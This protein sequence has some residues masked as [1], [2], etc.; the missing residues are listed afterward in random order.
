LANI[1]IITA[2]F[3]PEPVVS[4]GISYDIAAYLTKRNSVTVISPK[5][6][7]PY[8][9]LFPQQQVAFNFTHIISNSY[10]HAQSGF[11]GRFRESYSFGKYGYNY[12]VKNRKKIDLIYANTWPLMGQYFVV[13]A[14]KKCNIP[15][16]LHVQD[17]YPESLSK[18]LPYISGIVNRILLPLDRYVLKNSSAIAV[19]SKKMKNYL[20]K[21][22]KINIDKFHV[23]PNWQD[24]TLFIT[25]HV[26]ATKNEDGSFIFMYL[27]NVGPV[28]G[29]ELLI[30]AFAKANIKGARLIIA[31]D[32]SVKQ[33][34]IKESKNFT[35]SL[36]DFLP[37]PVGKVSELQSIADVL[38]LPIKKGN[39]STS[40]PSK[41]SGYMYSAKPIIACVPNDSDTARVINEAECGYVVELENEDLL[42]NTMKKI[43]RLNKSDLMRMGNNG[44]NYALQHL[45][46]NANLPKMISL[47]E[48]LL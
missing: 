20:A 37:V 8:G 35:G 23:I 47:I 26:K 43:Y 42:V 9:F 45:S 5:P 29:I 31:G 30:K 7:R 18:K 16:C 1:L 14:G 39:A 22:R 2:V 34:L 41:L 40:I 46:K 48:N 11:I 3:P 12:I 15:V 24:E 36:I 4:A 28:A 27:G 19:I 17:I 13:K 44:R 38:L 25:T 32:G 33:A 6:S 21:S 10:V